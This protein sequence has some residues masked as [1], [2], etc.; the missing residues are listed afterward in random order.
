MSD[1][2]KKK[3]LTD[4]VMQKLNLKQSISKPF[5]RHLIDMAVMFDKKQTDYGSN[6]ISDFGEFGVIVR[7]N[8]KMARIKNLT[9]NGQPPQNESLDDSYSDIGNYSVIALMLRNGEWS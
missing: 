5:I 6:N 1:E 2:L 9:K 3:E 4:L 7:M 8:D